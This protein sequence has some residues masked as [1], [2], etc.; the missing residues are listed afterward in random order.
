MQ[1]FV[2][3]LCDR[4]ILQVWTDNS[5][6]RIPNSEFRYVAPAG[7]NAIAKFLGQGLQIWRSQRVEAIA[8]NNSN[9]RLSLEFAHHEAS[10]N[11]LSEVKAKAV[12]FAIPAPQALAI[13]RTINR[14]FYIVRSTACCRI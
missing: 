14:S 11:Q 7:M 12:V 2:Q 1:Q 9:W 3:L 8:F 4:H 13:F 6:F 5:N 10:A